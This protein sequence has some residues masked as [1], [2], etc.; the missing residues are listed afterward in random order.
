MTRGP[1]AAPAVLAGKCGRRTV[2]GTRGRGPPGGGAPPR[3]ARRPE[4]CVVSGGRP[5][6]RG[7]AARARPRRPGS[8]GRWRLTGRGLGPRVLGSPAAP[9]SPGDASG[10]PPSDQPPCGTRSPEAIG[11]GAALMS[12]RAPGAG[13]AGARRGSCPPG[14]TSWPGNASDPQAPGG[15]RG[16]C[17][18][19][20]ALLGSGA[21]DGGGTVALAI[22]LPGVTA[23]P[24]RKSLNRCGG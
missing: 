18:R 23:P 12:P 17:A 11:T 15:R 21:M 9:A 4:S 24:S 1:G 3:G 16:R 20:S 6:P 19:G 7:R 5:G 22:A 13:G 2:R 8:C 14:P 10:G